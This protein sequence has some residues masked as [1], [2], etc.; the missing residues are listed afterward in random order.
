MAEGLL[1]HLSDGEIEVRSAGSDPDK[2]VA[3]KSIE[4]MNE[5]GIDISNHRPKHIDS[6]ADENF[7]WVITVCDSALQS[8]PVFHGSDGAAK[9][10]HW[11]IRD[12]H[13]EP[14]E[15][16]REVRDEISGR[17]GEWL[18]EVRSGSR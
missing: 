3:P 4:A 8:C 17:I 14:L 9:T 11:S 18:E 13:G 7:D 16:Y 6:I 15:T 5:I 10:L 1:R 2:Q 12:P